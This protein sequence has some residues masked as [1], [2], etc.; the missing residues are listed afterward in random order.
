MTT[1]ETVTLSQ[2]LKTHGGEVTT[3]TLKEPTAK[4]FFDHGEPFK[5][6]VVNDESGDR[7]ELDFF[8]GVLKKFLADMTG[9]DDLVLSALRAADFMTLR[10]RAAH[11]IMGLAGTNPIAT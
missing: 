2:P 7:I 10:T 11:M 6:R 5:V 3:I 4:S 8:N 9:L 1:T